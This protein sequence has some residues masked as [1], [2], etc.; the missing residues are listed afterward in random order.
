MCIAK[1]TGIG[2]S[3]CQVFIYEIF[4]HEIA[5]F[6]PDI[7]N[8]MCKA[9]LH[10]CLPRIVEAIYIAAT[11]FFFTA[12]TAAVIPCFHGNTHYFV[13]FIMKHEG[14]D[15]TVNTAAHGYQHFSFTTHMGLKKLEPQIYE[16]S[17]Y[18]ENSNRR[19]A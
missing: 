14:C 10:G 12:A 4:N 2:C 9:M 15:G 19:G 5:E 3:S 17:G 1:H 11:G 16:R 18:G 7:Q 8:I 6:F 13:A